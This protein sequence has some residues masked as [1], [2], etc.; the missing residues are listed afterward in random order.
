MILNRHEHEFQKE[1]IE[2]AKALE[3]SAYHITNIE[4]IPD[5]FLFKGTVGIQVELKIID[6]SK[7]CHKVQNAFQSTQKAFYIRQM[8]QSRTP[9]IIAFKLISDTPEYH[10]AHLH[11]LES[12][13]TFFNSKWKDFL[14]DPNKKYDV[15]QLVHNIYRKY[16]PYEITKF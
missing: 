11:S 12:I 15:L 6:E 8:Q 10:F 13:E 16:F 7:I 2:C 4:G 1:F 14:I 9:V 3:V 5:L